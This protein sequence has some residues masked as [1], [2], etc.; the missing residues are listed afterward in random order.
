MLSPGRRL[1]TVW[2]HELMQQ[3]L[4]SPESSLKTRYGLVKSHD[5]MI[6]PVVRKLLA[7]RSA[8][9]LS[10]TGE[11]SHGTVGCVVRDSQGRI[12]AGTSTGGV[13]LKHNGRVGDSPIIGSGVYADDSVA[14]ISTSGHGEEIL[15]ANLTGYTLA[16]WRSALEQNK[17]IFSDNPSLAQEILQ[18]EIV[19]FGRRSKGNAGM[20]AIPAGGDPIYGFNAPRFAIA[21]RYQSSS[22]ATQE[23]SQV[24]SQENL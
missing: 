5:E 6:A 15:M 8:A 4:S 12:A 9:E 16:A 11:G 17:S 21:A 3:I 13:Y 7:T 22:G 2:T 18:G 1:M 14:G 20:I 19:R 24:A 23:Y 10:T